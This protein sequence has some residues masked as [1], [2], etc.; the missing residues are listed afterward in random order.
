M[1]LHIEMRETSIYQCIINYCIDKSILSISEYSQGDKFFET[2]K[3]IIRDEAL[4]A[5]GT[6]HAVM[7]V[8]ILMQ[9]IM[10]EYNVRLEVR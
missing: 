8:N 5:T 10:Y 4:M 7:T 3:I 2:A 1:T 6:D 9:D